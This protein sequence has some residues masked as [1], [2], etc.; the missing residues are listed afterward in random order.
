[1]LSASQRTFTAISGA[2]APSSLQGTGR[3][4]VRGRQLS[5]ALILSAASAVCAQGSD[6]SVITSVD[7]RAGVHKLG[8]IAGWTR[9]QPLWQ[10]ERWQLKLRHEVSLAGWDVPKAKDLV[11]LGYSPFLRLHRALAGGGS[12]FVEGSIGV[13]LLSHTRVA[14]E[15]EFSTAF[16]FSDA[17]GVGIQWGQNARSTLGARVQHLSNLSIKRP[18]DGM[19]FVLLYYAHAF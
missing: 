14:R 15:R 17:L 19:D 1:M 2:V 8:I 5:L 4:G 10:G 13:H 12:V 18:N 6:W 16:Q 7:A 9:P 3:L 11:E